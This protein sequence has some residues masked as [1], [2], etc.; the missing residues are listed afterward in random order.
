[1]NYEEAKKIVEDLSI[2][3]EAEELSIK[4]VMGEISADEAICK[5]NK[6]EGLTKNA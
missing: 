1:M 2:S 5:L 4:V 6:K 3:K